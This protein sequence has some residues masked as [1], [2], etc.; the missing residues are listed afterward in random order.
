MIGLK[1]KEVRVPGHDSGLEQMARAGL[2]RMNLLAGE[3]RETQRAGVS[4]DLAK[5]ATVARDVHALEAHPPVA[6][7]VDDGVGNDVDLPR[8]GKAHHPGGGRRIKQ[9]IDVRS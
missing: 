2:S 9:A 5:L 7:A 6:P 8:L 1:G 4:Q 3:S